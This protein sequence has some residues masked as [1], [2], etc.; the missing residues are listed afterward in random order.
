MTLRSICAVELLRVLE[1]G[2]RA[3]LQFSASRTRSI[4][5]DIAAMIIAAFAILLTAVSLGTVL[6]ILHFRSEGAVAPAW[7]FAGLHGLL[8]IGGFGCLLLGLRGPPRGLATRGGSVGAISATL[9]GLAL[10][11]GPECL[12]RVFSI[13]VS[14]ESSSA[15]TPRL[16]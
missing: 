2:E 13:D 12:R 3:H 6:A 16:W 9:V 14:R 10:L 15:S 1:E 11:F 8:A 4:N 7:P 5:F